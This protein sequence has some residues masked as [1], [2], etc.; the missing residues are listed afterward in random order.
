MSLPAEARW[1]YDWKPKPGSR[2][3]F[4]C[5]HYLQPQEWTSVSGEKD[6]KLSVAEVVADPRKL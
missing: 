4:V 5:T 2:E 1:R 3:E 6:L